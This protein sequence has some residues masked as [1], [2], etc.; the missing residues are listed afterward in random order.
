[1]GGHCDCLVKEKESLKNHNCQAIRMIET[2]QVP[3][4]TGNLL[5]FNEV[6]KYLVVDLGLTPTTVTSHKNL[7]QYYRQ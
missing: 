5:L 3:K 1:M 2:I 4:F 7:H 6:C